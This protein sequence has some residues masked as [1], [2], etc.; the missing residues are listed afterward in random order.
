MKKINIAKEI[1][2]LGKIQRDEKV[3]AESLAKNCKKDELISILMR[4][5]YAK[6]AKWDYNFIAC[7]LVFEKTLYLLK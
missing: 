5:E 6:L 4:I 3:N 7:E 1:M 2:K